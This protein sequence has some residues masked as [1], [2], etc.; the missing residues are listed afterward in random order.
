MTATQTAANGSVKV[1]FARQYT[2][3]GG[4]VFMRF[5]ATD[6]RTAEVRVREGRGGV[7]TFTR[8]EARLEAMRRLGI[9]LPCPNGCGGTVVPGAWIDPDMPC[10][11]PASR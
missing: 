10:P 7:F 2:T 5:Q 9:G 11:S 6:G 1:R 4:N 3:G 8:R